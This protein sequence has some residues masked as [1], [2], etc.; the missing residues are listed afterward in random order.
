MDKIVNIK[1]F[2]GYKISTSGEV[3]TDHYLHHPI[4]RKL[5]PRKS[6]NGY[7]NVLLYKDNKG[8]SK[9]I[10]RLVAEAF[11]PNLY[12][13]PQ[14]NHI[15]GNKLNNCVDNLEWCDNSYN[16]RHAIRNGLIDTG[17]LLN[18]TQKMSNKNKKSVL[19]F[20]LE[21]NFIAEYDSAKEA[22]K[23]CGLTNISACCIGK[24]K[25]AGGFL[26]RYKN[27]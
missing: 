6:K 25:T 24:Y 17:R 14:V 4:K 18:S 12:N 22:A 10:H 15:D 20:D 2:P 23:S 13:L 11:I 3:F 27:D 8:Y 21:G 5:K 7:Y 16:I 9:S 26:W 19:Q 1:G